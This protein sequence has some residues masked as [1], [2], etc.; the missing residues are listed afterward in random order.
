M[1][2]ALRSLSSALA[3]LLGATGCITLNVG[4]TPHEPLVESVVY[5]ESGPKILLLDIQGVIQEEP[6]SGAFG[7]G[8]RESLVARVREQLQKAEDEGVE[9]LLLRVNS[10]GG[11]ATASEILYREIARFREKSGV[12]VVAQMMGLATSGAYY[13]SMSA[14]AVYAHPTTVTG[15]IGVIFSG[16][17]FSGLMERF[18]VSNQT[19]TGGESKD[20]GSPFRPMT[21]A[22][23]AQLQSVIDELH[24]RFKEVV[25]QGREGLD[26]A[27]V[28]KLADGRIYSAKQALAHGLID[29]IG[30]LPD[31]VKEI[32]KRAGLSESRVVAYHRPGEWR[33]N[34][35]SFQAP[36]APSLDLGRLFTPVAGP[37]FLY[38]WWP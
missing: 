24:A 5:G 22:E 35:Y 1:K 14:E 8:G 19:I 23:R 28:G 21:D 26:S 18:G 37:A 17:N 2:G 12:P 11:T 4:G 20:V 31:A 3:V 38:L 34:L 16:L 6:E 10:P 7:I 15:S 29:G 9:A 25:A 32:E 13:V 36:A 33:K 30:D 27:A